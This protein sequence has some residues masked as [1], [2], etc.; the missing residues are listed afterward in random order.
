MITIL[1]E[2]LKEALY[3]KKRLMDKLYSYVLAVLG[4]GSYFIAP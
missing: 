3:V 2:K 1:A 4:D